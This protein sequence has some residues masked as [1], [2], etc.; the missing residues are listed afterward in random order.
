MAAVTAPGGRSLFGKLAAAAAQR[1]AVRTR[2]PSRAAAFI[3][4]HLLT[5]CALGAG[6]TAGFVHGETWGLVSLVPALLIL[7]FK[8]RG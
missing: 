3:T 7:D 8:I 2:R 4:D 6:V 5:A 1:A